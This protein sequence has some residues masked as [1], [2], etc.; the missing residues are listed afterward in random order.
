MCCK[1]KEEVLD[2]PLWRT[3]NGRG[4][5]R[6]VKQTAEWFNSGHSEVSEVE[7]SSATLRVSLV[8]TSC[9]CCQWSYQKAHKLVAAP[10]SQQ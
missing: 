4:C 6:V 7:L 9:A 1:L 5:G 2:R 8:V 10:Y 3:R